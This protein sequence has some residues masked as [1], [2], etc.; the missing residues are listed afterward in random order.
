MVECLIFV[1]KGV[2]EHA[3]DT[4]STGNDGRALGGRVVG[5]RRAVETCDADPYVA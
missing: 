4:A 2:N 1:Y 3:W 5:W